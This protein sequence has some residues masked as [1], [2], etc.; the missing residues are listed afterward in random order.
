M[1]RRCR[2]LADCVTELGLANASVLRVRRRTLC[3]ERT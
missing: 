1:E 3:C 2:F